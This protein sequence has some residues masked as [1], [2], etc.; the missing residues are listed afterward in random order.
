MKNYKE[1]T[2]DELE[3]I[4]YFKKMIIDIAL[5]EKPNFRSIYHRVFYDS[6]FAKKPLPGKGYL[7]KDLMPPDEMKLYIIAWKQV[8]PKIEDK[9]RQKKILIKKHM[10]EQDYESMPEHLSFGLEYLY[11]FRSNIRIFFRRQ[12]GYQKPLTKEQNKLVNYYKRIISDYNF[13]TNHDYSMKC[14]LKIID[15]KENY[16]LFIIAYKQ[17]IKKI[18]KMERVKKERYHKNG[19]HYINPRITFLYAIRTIIRERSRN[20]NNS[21]K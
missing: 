21:I 12:S 15:D 3:K 9:I 10:R 2:K 1:K 13:Y 4:D 11:G 7:F 14:L 17:I 19:S 5:S 20:Q 18:E 16:W 6:I 8:L